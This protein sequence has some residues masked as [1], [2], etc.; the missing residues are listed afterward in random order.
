MLTM[1]VAVFLLDRYFDAPVRRLLTRC[2]TKEVRSTS[3][4]GNVEVSR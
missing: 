2:L 4:R 1:F 3:N